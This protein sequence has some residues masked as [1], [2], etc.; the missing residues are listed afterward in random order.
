MM[1]HNHSGYYWYSHE[2]C[3]F[4]KYL[5]TCHGFFSKVFHEWW[6]AIA[7]YHCKLSCVPQK[8]GLDSMECSSAKMS[9]QSTLAL[10]LIK[11]L[12]SNY[13]PTNFILKSLFVEPATIVDM[14]EA[15]FFC[16]NGL[17]TT[18]SIWQRGSL[19]NLSIIVHLGI[20][21]S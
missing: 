3:Q 16:T 18:K 15:W 2:K 1:S 13:F 8:A 21:Q 7:Y 12:A 14:L 4:A 17:S 20:S 9:F 19:I 10:Q 6:L 5:K 11:L